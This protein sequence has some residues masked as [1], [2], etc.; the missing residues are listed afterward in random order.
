MPQYIENKRTIGIRHRVKRTTEGESRPTQVAIDRGDG[1]ILTLELAT[2]QDELDF[3]LGVYPTK[4]K[5]SPE[6]EVPKETL[7]H[8]IKPTKKEGVV[9][10]P[11]SHEG[12]RD[13]DDVL[14]TL[15][16][17]GNMLA[18][19]I[20]KIGEGRNIRMFR[21]PPYVL[22]Q[23]RVL[24]DS[25]DKDLDPARLIQI[26]KENG[27]LFY[28]VGPKER[29]HILVQTL[30]R[31]KTDAMRARIMCEQRLCQRSIGETFK[32]LD[33]SGVT[34]IEDSLKALKAN[35]TTLTALKKEENRISRELEKALEQHTVYTKIFQP[36]EG[37]GPSI[38]A[39]II[40]TVPD[41]DLFESSAKLKAFFGV[42]VLGD[43]RQVR[44]RSGTRCNWN[45]N[46]RQGLFLLADQ[47]VKR[48]DSIWGIKLRENKEALREK[49]PEKSDVTEYWLPMSQVVL[50]EKGPRFIAR[51]DRAGNHSAE[52]S[53]YVRVSRD[54]TPLEGE[55][56]MYTVHDNVLSVLSADN[57]VKK[58]FKNRYSKGHIHKM[59]I[60][61]TLNQFVEWLFD[62]W[63]KVDESALENGQEKAA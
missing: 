48:K 41:I 51:F 34:S 63:K 49:Y 5:E 27:L 52:G 7:K 61:K 37:V 62:E 19:A 33:T 3:I 20:S 15:G 60:W 57:L 22:K 11:S 38:A 4:W 1:D 12:L 25:D 21:T 40:S 2:E 43:G 47:F 9:K 26:Y 56:E 50:P 45:P 28:E 8:H 6:D 53:E 14:M 54:F 35:D 39:R 18:F 46:A 59:A 10:I 29:R 55:R 44:K 36:I 23:A 17:S 58:V 13:D 24:Q 16:G 42:H 32:M 31:E 30:H